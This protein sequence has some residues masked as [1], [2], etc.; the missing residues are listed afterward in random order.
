MEGGDFNKGYPTQAHVVDGGVWG[1]LRRLGLAGRITSLG[2]GFVREEECHWWGGGRGGGG[3][4][5]MY[6]HSSGS[7]FSDVI[8]QFFAPASTKCLLL[9]SA[10][11]P[12]HYRFLSLWNRKSK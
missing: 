9:A 12:L 7:S 4:E 8:S 11:Q 3:F 10:P 6:L 1:K 2:V 5:T